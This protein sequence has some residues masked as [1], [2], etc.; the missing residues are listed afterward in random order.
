M[1]RDYE[2]YLDDIVIAIVMIEKYVTNLNFEE[3]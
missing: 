2:G 3:C 1:S